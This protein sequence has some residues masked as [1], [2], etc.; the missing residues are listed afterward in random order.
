MYID[1][2][3]NKYNTYKYNDG[4]EFIIFIKDSI[5]HHRDLHHY[6]L[7]IVIV[8]CCRVDIMKYLFLVIEYILIELY[9]DVVLLIGMFISRAETRSYI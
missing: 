6:R 7:N 1:F 4:L 9:D 5:H 8:L 3:T 2:L